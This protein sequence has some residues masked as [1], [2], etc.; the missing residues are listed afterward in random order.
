MQHFHFD[1]A[2][3]LNLNIF[4]G[5]ER[6]RLGRNA[7]VIVI[8][9]CYSSLLCKKLFYFR[10]YSGS[11]LWWDVRCVNFSSLRWYTSPFL[12]KLSLTE[13]GLTMESGLTI[14]FCGIGTSLTLLLKKF[15]T[16][17]IDFIVFILVLM[18]KTLFLTFFSNLITKELSPWFSE[19]F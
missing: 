9:Q 15:W 5:I 6:V 12:L 14:F 10:W 7:Y 1:S 11:L 2:F 4:Y 17:F 18:C 19:M 13:D 16:S 3:P 8:R